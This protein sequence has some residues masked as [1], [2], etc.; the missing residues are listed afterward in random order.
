MDVNGSS[1][2]E[3]FDSIARTAVFGGAAH[4]N[5]TGID[6]ADTDDVDCGGACAND[7]RL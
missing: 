3:V 1:V 4:G 7:H 2:D 5:V 6:D